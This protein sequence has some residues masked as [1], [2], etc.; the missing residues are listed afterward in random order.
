[1]LQWI[2]YH[3]ALK[4]PFFYD[5]A[6]AKTGCLCIYENLYQALANNLN[7]FEGSK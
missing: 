5:R 1:M 4:M 2:D 6:T 3:I 7:L